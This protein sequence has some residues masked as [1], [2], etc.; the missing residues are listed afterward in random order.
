MAIDSSFL[1]IV[2]AW[3]NSLMEVRRKSSA[4]QVWF[5][6]FREG[7]YCRMEMIFIYEDFNSFD[8][9]DLIN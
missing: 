5:M 4:G 7:F 9:K 1:Y 3:Q 6:I 2:L 8:S